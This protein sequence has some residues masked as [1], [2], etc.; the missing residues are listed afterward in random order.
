MYVIMQKERS[1]NRQNPWE[2][3]PKDP[4]TFHESIEEAARELLDRALSWNSGAP[5]PMIFRIF[6]VRIA[7]GAKL[8]MDRISAS[9]AR[10]AHED[11]DTM[12]RADIAAIG[13]CFD[14]RKPCH[15]D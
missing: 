8:A 2:P 1:D 7:E 5:T 6:E 9:L 4:V 13:L 10:D 15:E 3:F 11:V 14:E 12:R